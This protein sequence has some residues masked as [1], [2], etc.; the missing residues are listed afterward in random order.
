MSCCRR[1]YIFIF[2]FSGEGSLRKRSE[3]LVILFWLSFFF[4]CYRTCY[5]NYWNLKLPWA[6][7]VNVWYP[8]ISSRGYVDIDPCPTWEPWWGKR[9]LSSGLSCLS[10]QQGALLPFLSNKASLPHCFRGSWEVGPGEPKLVSH[11]SYPS[12]SVQIGI[13]QRTALFIGEQQLTSH[14]EKTLGELQL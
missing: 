12:Y 10:G 8:Y 6:R 9:I 14:P 3:Y 4:F 11:H 1:L 13:L 7:I 5:A 2:I